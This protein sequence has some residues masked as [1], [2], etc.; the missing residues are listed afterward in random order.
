MIVIL[1][2]LSIVSVRSGFSFIWKQT[3]YTVVFRD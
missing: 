3:G 2:V 1:V